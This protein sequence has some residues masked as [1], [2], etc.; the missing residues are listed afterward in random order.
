MRHVPKVFVAAV[1]GSLLV[2]TGA[3][4]F[5]T[6]PTG[7]VTTT[8]LAN[9]T[10]THA[11]N[12]TTKVTGGNVTVRT[13]GALDV[14]VVE[15][16]LA[17]GATTGWHSHSGPHFEVV[18]QGTLTEISAKGCKSETLQAGQSTWD[19]SPGDVV[20]GVNHGT[21]PV[22]FVTTFVAPKGS[23]PRVDQPAPANCPV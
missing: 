23:V 8:I 13:K 15:I 4:A 21:E 12:A 9:G 1:M 19:S 18:K 14:D 7:G 11:I 6:P 3:T 5:A 22:T 10:L 20:I 16:T 17:P 2:F